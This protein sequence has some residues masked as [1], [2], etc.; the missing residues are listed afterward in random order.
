M[1]GWPTAG[2]ASYLPGMD[3]RPPGRRRGSPKG[4]IDTLASGSVRVRVYAG[5]DVLTGKDH[6]LS[7]VIPAGPRA[8][9]LAEE[10]RARLVELVASGKQPK[11][12]A[13]ISQLLRSHLD[14]LAPD[15]RSRHSLECYIGKHIDPLIGK[16]SIGSVRTF[17][18]EWFYVELR[19]C[20]DHCDGQ[21][22]IRHRVEGEHRCTTKCKPHVCRP[23][24]AATIRKLRFLMNAAFT[25]AVVWEW[26]AENPVKTARKPSP[27]APK[28][29]PP[30]V[31]EA[32]A[33]LNESWRQGY[34]AF[35]WLAMTTGARRGELCALR[36]RSLTVRHAGEGE[37]DCV[38]HSCAW[39]LEIRRSLG[40][41]AGEVWESDTKTHQI[42]KIA[43]D[44][45]TVAVLLTH[46][47]QVEREAAALGFVVNDDCFMFAAAPDG[48]TPMKPPSITQR[49]ARWARRLGIKTTLKSLR[50]YSATELIISGVD[51]RTVAGRLGHAGGGT[52][53]L[54]VYTAWVSEAD[55][56]AAMTLMSSMP[57]R[58][59]ALLHAARDTRR[60]DSPYLSITDALTQRVA[61][62]ELPVGAPIPTV[63]E[64]ALEYR[65]SAGTAHRAVS[66]LTDAGLVSASRGKRAMV[67][68]R[69][70]N[71][72]Q[73]PEPTDPGHTQEEP[74]A[75]KQWVL[76]ETTHLAE[77]LQ[78]STAVECEPRWASPARGSVFTRRRHQRSHLSS[79]WT[80]GIRQGPAI[81][82]SSPGCIAHSCFAAGSTVP[83]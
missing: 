8:A 2:S 58:P 30:T 35:V 66:V 38:E 79:P 72:P 54:K 49:Y 64:L 23:L 31:D 44:P 74:S 56:R 46:R 61:R 78:L 63:K 11:T 51:I 69:P 41:H 34:G 6:Y 73:A 82:A 43:L 75:S 45:E 80:G 52:T 50:H 18:V 76:V 14:F 37:H 55:Q 9:A 7:E 22:F 29:E 47:K 68:A 27:P 53:T 1:A 21:P 17:D 19:R 12:N 70:A 15:P 81:A 32:A 25:N 4:S 57:S 5:V 59:A 24:G 3:V 28:P 20:R 71:A 26:I 33:L 67:I 42:R 65:V 60:Q 39:T 40:C 13:T 83:V 62:G 16:R 10:A 48:V 36:W 77:A